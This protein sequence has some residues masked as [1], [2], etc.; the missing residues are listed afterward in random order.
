[1]DAV[2]M[3]PDAIGPSVSSFGALLLVVLLLI[4]PLLGAT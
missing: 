4:V 3:M 2:T 1:V